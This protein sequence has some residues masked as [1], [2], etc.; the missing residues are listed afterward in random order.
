MRYQYFIFVIPAIRQIASSGTP[1]V[2]NKIGNQNLDLWSIKFW[3]SS[4]FFSP[5]SFDANFSPNLSPKKNN[6]EVEMK[7]E[8]MLVINAILAPNIAIPKIARVVFKRGTKH[9]KINAADRIKV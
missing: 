6:T 9:N 5:I 8:I 3:V 7:T 2:I 1:G 4:R